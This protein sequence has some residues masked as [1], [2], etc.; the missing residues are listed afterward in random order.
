MTRWEKFAK[1]KGIQKKKRSRKEYDD[2]KGEYRARY[3]YKGSDDRVPDDWVME[4]PHNAG[5]Y[6]RTRKLYYNDLA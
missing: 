5:G 4:V 2:D 1:A 6:S 3:G